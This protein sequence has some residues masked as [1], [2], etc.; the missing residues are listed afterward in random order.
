MRGPLNAGAVPNLD[1][2]RDNKPGLSLKKDAL[3]SPEDSEKIQRFR[4][5]PAGE[6][7]LSGPASLVLFAA[8]QN[9]SSDSIEVEVALVDCPGGAGQCAPFAAVTIM[10]AGTADQFT[11]LT[12][13]FGPQDHV[14]APSNR[15][16]LWIIDTAASHHHMWI[17]YDTVGYESALTLS[18]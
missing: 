2:D 15:L 6:M 1:V 7:H 8:P 12:F 3:L 13:D 9:L 18:S 14:I 10:F 5:D 17:A 4:L 16:E 11:A